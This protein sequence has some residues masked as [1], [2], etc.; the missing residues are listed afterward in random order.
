L[1]GHC[2]VLRFDCTY[3]YLRKLKYILSFTNQLPQY[4]IVL[5]V[6]CRILKIWEKVNSM[7]R[8]LF[9]HRCEIFSKILYQTCVLQ[10]A[11]TINLFLLHIFYVTTTQD[12]KDLIIYNKR[13][14][15]GG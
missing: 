7:C 3:N 14:S 8:N 13:G 15:L 12:K 1:L 6:V 11:I 4:L 2:P 5:G 9:E 10:P